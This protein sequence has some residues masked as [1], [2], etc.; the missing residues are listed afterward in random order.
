MA[1]GTDWYDADK[2][3]A[4]VY[5]VLRYL[6]DH[7][8]EGAACVGN[9]ANAQQLFEKRGEI[10]IPTEKGAR[11]VFF[12]AGEQELKHG[13]SVIIEVPSQPLTD[14]TDDQLKA[15]ILGNYPYWPPN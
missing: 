5:K 13:S 4:A 10:E 12:A 2:K 8:E 7:P 3:S 9:D 15:Y 14:A 1:N 6:A 11:V